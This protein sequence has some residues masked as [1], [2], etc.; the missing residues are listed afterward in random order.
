MYSDRW[1]TPSF[2]LTITV[3]KNCI[4]GKQILSILTIDIVLHIHVLV[5][6]CRYSDASATDCDSVIGFNSEYACHK[7]WTGSESPQSSTWRELSAIEFSLQS[8]APVLKGSHVKWFTDNQAA[9]RIVEVGSMKLELQRMARRIFDVC[10]QS[11]I[12]LD[13]SNGFPVL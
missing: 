8:F 3:R 11:E 12:Y 1:D 2:T 7:M 6:L 10:V 4:F 9:A 13:V 5:H